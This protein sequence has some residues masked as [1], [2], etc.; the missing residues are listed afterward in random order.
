M[1]ASR[2]PRV[3][4]L[5]DHDA[6]RMYMPEELERMGVAISPTGLPVF[7]NVG[8]VFFN[9]T[10]QWYTGQM[11]EKRQPLFEGDICKVGVSTE[12]GSLVE[13]YA[14]MRWV[15]DTRQFILQVRNPLAGQ[16]I[17]IG[18]CVKLGDEYQNPE[19]LEKVN[20]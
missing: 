3:F 12:F 17:D 10:I 14:I 16:Y 18:A 5:Y 7:S 15:P 19:L 8:H 2:F 13:D 1:R 9:S 11:D 4:R 20:G 6:K